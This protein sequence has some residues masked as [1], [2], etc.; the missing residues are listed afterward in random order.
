MRVMADRAVL[1]DRLVVLD[2]RAALFHMTGVAGFIHAIAFHEFGSDRTVRV[3]AISTSHIALWNRMVGRPL[4]LRALFLVAGEANL[5]LGA[6]V[7]H[8]IV[9]SVDYMAGGAGHVRKL[10]RT[11]FPVRAIRILAVAGKTGRI[12]YCYIAG[13]VVARCPSFCSKQN[14]GSSTRF[15]VFF[16]F[17][18]ARLAIGR[19]GIRLDAVRGLVD[20]KDGLYLIFIMTARANLV[21]FH[22]C[23]RQ[24]NRWWRYLRQN[25]S[26]SRSRG[27]N[28][29]H[30]NTGS[31]VL[32]HKHILSLR[33]R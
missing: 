12:L 33:N 8:L 17:A 29:N 15:Q 13:R 32:L 21:L 23:R 6:F 19:A 16:T 11:S 28:R 26:C 5:G 14:V 1:A 3:M 22:G 7:A 25:R 30:D 10:M 24:I 4:E 2:E 20:S 27:W 31:L 9:R 18:V